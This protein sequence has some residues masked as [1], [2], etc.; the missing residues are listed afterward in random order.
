MNI[1]RSALS[2]HEYNFHQHDEQEWTKGFLWDSDEENILTTREPLLSCQETR[3]QSVK[4]C[5][6][7]HYTTR[8]KRPIDYHTR[9]V[10]FLVYRCNPPPLSL[11]RFTQK[12]AFQMKKLPKPSVNPRSSQKYWP[13]GTSRAQFA[14]PPSASD[15]FQWKLAVC[16]F[17][18]SEPFAPL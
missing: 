18:I 10:F 7:W 4:N 3:L 12:K 13:S 15:T 8:I 2:N 9:L 17:W 11:L 16:H 14:I 1:S 5:E 6:S